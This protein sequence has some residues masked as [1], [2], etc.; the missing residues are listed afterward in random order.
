M[1]CPWLENYDQRSEASTDNQRSAD[2]MRNAEVLQQLQTQRE[3]LEFREQ[4]LRD[5][6]AQLE[7][8]VGR[9]NQGLTE[10]PWGGGLPI[11]YLR[12]II[13]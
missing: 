5:Q 12:T 6:Q 7:L 11:E 4:I 1:V 8:K 2:E 3:D 10:N 13:D 9:E